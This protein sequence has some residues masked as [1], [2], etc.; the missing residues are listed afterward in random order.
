MMLNNGAK[1]QIEQK[2]TINDILNVYIA[3]QDVRKEEGGEE[4]QYATTRDCKFN[5]EWH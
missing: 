4:D 1:K 5:K 3:Q 2:L